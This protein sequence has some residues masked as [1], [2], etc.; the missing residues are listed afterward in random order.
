[1]QPGLEIQ[2]KIEVTVKREFKIRQGCV[3]RV[4]KGIKTVSGYGM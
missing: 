1:L 2:I 4:L 3:G